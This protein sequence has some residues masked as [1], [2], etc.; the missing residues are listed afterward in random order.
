MSNWRFLSGASLLKTFGDDPNGPQAQ[1]AATCRGRRGTQSGPRPPRWRNAPGAGGLCRRSGVSF[2]ATC[3]K[4]WAGPPE[5]G[6][7]HEVEEF[8]KGK[9]TPMVPNRSFLQGTPKL[10]LCFWR[11]FKTTVPS[12][13]DTPKQ[14]V[15]K[16]GTY[17]LFLG[18]LTCRPR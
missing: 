2:F 16:K 1:A 13:Q 10:W 11:S 9:K 5:K 14:G 18:K 3:E 6:I 7:L 4:I 15:R 17:V 12:K 8:S